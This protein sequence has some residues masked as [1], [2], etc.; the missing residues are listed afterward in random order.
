MNISRKHSLALLLSLGALSLDVSAQTPAFPGAEGFGKFATGARGGSVYHVT[1]LAD[2]GAGSFRDAV[3]V[4]GRTVV[5]DI[6]GVIDYQAPRYAP[7]ANITIAGQTAPG[8]GITIYGNGL[9]FSGANNNICRFIRVR[10]GIVGDSGTDAMGIANG[11]TMIFDHITSSWGRDETF[12]I[13]GS[14]TNITI[15]SAIISQGLQ[16]HSAGGLIQTDG[17]VSILRTLYID[18]DT[19]NPK[20]KGVNEYVN[21][22]ICNWETIGYNMGGDSAG[23]SFVNNFNNYFIC[24][25]ASSSS[26]ITGGNIDFHIYATNNWYDGNKDGVLNGSELSLDR[27]STRLNS[28]HGKLSRMPS[29][30]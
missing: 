22:V 9:S 7:K 26:A 2:S 17:G 15:Q 20:V 19:R 16:G 27:K 5:F 24:G 14:I 8:G 3:S 18:N 4:S 30:A 13:S 11:N 1:T 25:Q 6:G 12:S 28:S 23:E 29:S 10:E 21:N